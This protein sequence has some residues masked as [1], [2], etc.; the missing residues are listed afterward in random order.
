MGFHIVLNPI[1]NIFLQV[2]H[3][4]QH[5]SY[6]LVVIS[7][8]SLILS[9]P[10][11]LYISR[12]GTVDLQCTSSLR[13]H[14]IVILESLAVTFIERVT[15]VY[16]FICK[17]ISYSISCISIIL[18]K[19]WWRLFPS[20]YADRFTILLYI[21]NIQRLNCQFLQE[22][23]L[24]LYFKLFLF[25]FNPIQFHYL[26]LDVSQLFRKCLWRIKDLIENHANF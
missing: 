22:K 15:F 11:S 20:L 3:L 4:N 9:I 7:F 24:Q 18:V 19:S 2:N 12:N 10:S 14:I 6:I 25:L 5:T 1:S 23:V 16:V 21:Y 17:E 8:F 13:K 26:K